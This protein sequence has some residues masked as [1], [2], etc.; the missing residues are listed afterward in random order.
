[1]LSTITE[2]L[3]ELKES[4][5]PTVAKAEDDVEDAGEEE[6]DDDEDEDE[7][8]EEEEAQ[9]QLDALRQEALETEEGKGLNHHYHECVERVTK[10]QEDPN[11]ENLEYKEDCVEEFFHLQHHVDSYAAP[12]LFSQLK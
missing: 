8:E 4:F 11:Y 1:M 7:D 12:R 9:D 6:D 5:V 2:Y 10:Q 3:E